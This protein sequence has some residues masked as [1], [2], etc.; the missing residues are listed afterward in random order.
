MSLFPAYAAS[1]PSTSIEQNV[2]QTDD[3]STYHFIVLDPDSPQ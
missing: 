3:A 1:E 2:P